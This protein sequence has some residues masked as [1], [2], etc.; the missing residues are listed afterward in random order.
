MVDALAETPA[1]FVTGDWKMGNLGR[2]AD[3]RTVLVDQAYP[4]QAPGLYDLL[5]YVALNRQRLP[6]SKEATIEA[7]RAGLE[8]AGIDT[9]G[10]FERQLGL[11]VDRGDGDLRLGEGARR[12]RRAGVVVG[13]GAE[14][15]SVAAMTADDGLAFARQGYEGAATAWADGAELVYGPMA[16]ALLARAPELAGRL[17]LD[18]G[19]GTGAVSRRLL[20][21]G[22]DAV[23]VDASWPML[24]HQASS[25]PPAV[26]GDISRLPLVDGAVDGAAAAF[27]LNHLADPVAALVEMRRVVRRGGFI[28]ASVFSTAD[29]P[30]AKAAID[31]ALTTAGWEP[32]EWYRFLKSVDGQLGT[33]A[34]MRDAAQAADLEH[35][36]VV[37]RP[38]PTGVTDPRDIVRYRL[39]QPQTGPFLAELSET[40]RRRVVDECVAAVAETRRGLRP[41]RRAAGSP[42][43]TPPSMGRDQRRRPALRCHCQALHR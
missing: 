42:R 27:V 24:A 6:V 32:P 25:R 5:W 9:G 11:S 17:V 37:D 30:A 41:R 16:D 28:V 10:W 38:V 13:P 15:T 20:A 33:A 40:A 36:D 31:G 21:A 34:T 4:G 26:V 7:Y 23:A 1:T 3:G 35:I 14:G 22:A 18:V 8:A 2:H 43:L 12:C 19:A 29:P 39:S